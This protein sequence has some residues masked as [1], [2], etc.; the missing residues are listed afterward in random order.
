MGLVLPFVLVDAL[1]QSARYSLLR[2]QDY[3][4]NLPLLG[5]LACLWGSGLWRRLSSSE[6]HRRARHA[7][8]LEEQQQL[9]WTGKKRPQNPLLWHRVV[10]SMRPIMTECCQHAFVRTRVS[11]CRTL[12][13]NP[14]KADPCQFCSDLFGTGTGLPCAM[15][16]AAALTRWV[17][18]HSAPW[19]AH[20]TVES[21]PANPIQEVSLAA[22]FWFVRAKCYEPPF[23]CG[24]PRPPRIHLEM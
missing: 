23:A 13:R 12:T 16:R 15:A 24:T 20:M 4:A 3:H 10:A 5:V 18:L 11:L 2:P 22:L 9:S 8:L 19:G 14:V 7:T 21:V 6:P 1:T 17:L